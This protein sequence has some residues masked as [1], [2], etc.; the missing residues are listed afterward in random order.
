MAGRPRQRPRAGK[1]AFAPR[2]IE[3]A[4]ESV[5]ARGD[6]V[7]RVGGEPLFVPL[8]APGDR[9]VARIEGR[10]GDGLAASLVE[11]LSP[12]PLRVAP[13]CPHFGTCGGC[14]LQHLSE[15]FYASWKRGLV[16]EALSRTVGEVPLAPLVRVPWGARRRATFGFAKRRGAITVGFNARASHTLVDIAVC[17]LLVP[18]LS[19][20]LPPLRAMLAGIAAEG[21]EGDVTVTQTD[22][23]LDVLV[24]GEARL[25]LL[26]RERLAAFAEAQD[27]A[28]LSWRR[29]GGVT[30][31]LAARRPA[32]VAFAGVPVLPPP[33]G[34]LQPSREGEAAICDLVLAAVGD[35]R[36]V[37]DLYCGCG[38]FTVPL[39][40]RG[41]V[42]GVEGDS[43]A[44][45][46]LKAAAGQA[47]LP[48]TVDVR[49]LSVRPLLDHELK[50]FKAVV[51]DPPRAG[52]LAQARVLAAAGPPVVVAVS[53]NPA[54]L[55]RDLGVLVDGGYAVQRVTA[56]DQF[57]AAAHVEAVAVLRR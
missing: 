28:R 50:R 26:D 17:P 38:S 1:P 24:Q 9:V 48:V 40:R 21:E 11:V 18:E 27:L 3:V 7:A 54:T 53:C 32:T 43:H 12:G 5:G 30:E 46:A 57:P 10:K 41:P 39:A 8:T 52:A 33:G 16:A 4:I 49:D 34:F 22:N 13:A 14:A 19:R 29:P 37:V 6:G 55:A 42:H 56:I 2:T 36:P 45:A 15:D 20:L 44:A 47:G 51:F 23:G 31:P 25:D 35:P